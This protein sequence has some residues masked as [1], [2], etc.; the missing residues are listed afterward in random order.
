MLASIAGNAFCYHRAPLRDD[1]SS[2]AHCQSQLR[3]VVRSEI[4][5]VVLGM[6]MIAC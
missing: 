3:R 6:L 1:F 4:W 2:T 5:A